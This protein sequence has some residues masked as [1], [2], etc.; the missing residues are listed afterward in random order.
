MEEMLWEKVNQFLYQLHY[1][2]T[3]R[4]THYES[5]AF[6]KA[7]IEREEKRA[8]CEIVLNSLSKAKRQKI[9]DY[10]TASNQCSYEEHQQA[11]IQGMIDCIQ[12]LGGAGI[13]KPRKTVKELL[14]NI[15]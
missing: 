3:D 4:E 12:I 2:D 5:H 6:E 8:A 1:E 9:E 10:I 15:K 7:K 14:N 11:Y 13:I